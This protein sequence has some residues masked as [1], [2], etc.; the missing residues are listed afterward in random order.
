MFHKKTCSYKFRNIHRKTPVL[1]S[2]VNKVAGLK[3]Y[4]F[5]KKRFQHR[6]FPVN[7]Q[8]I[9]RTTVLKNIRESLLLK[10][11]D[12]IKIRQIIYN[13]YKL[14]S[15]TLTSCFESW[16]E[17]HMVRKVSNGDY[18]HFPNFIKK[19]TLTQVFSWEFCEIFKNT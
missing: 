8:K 3:A 10:C 2:L 17:T 4:N 15:T 11:Y 1:E 9:L 5:I 18:M 16:Q 13:T 14:V 7:I 19:E 12:Y 6:C